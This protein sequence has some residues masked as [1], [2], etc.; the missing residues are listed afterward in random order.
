MDV[1]TLRSGERE[2]LLEL[3]DG[4]EIG[5]GWRGRDFFRR[6]LELDPTYA[7]ENVWVAV[8]DGRL[9]CCV[10]IFPRQLR[11]AGRPVPTGGIGS[12]FSRPERRGEGL[13]ARV[14]ARAEAA[15]AERGMELA[16]LF[17]GP[18]AWYEGLGWSAWPRRR[19]LLARTESAPAVARRGEPFDAARDL[20]AVRA[21]HE[22]CDAGREGCVIRDD[23]LWHASLRV[24]GNPR[25]DFLVAR[26]A[27]RLVAYARAIVLN[28]L[29]V[30]SEYAWQPGGADAL[31]GLVVE[32]MAARDPDPLARD[33]G[34]EGD[35]R[36]HAVAGA[37]GL[38]AELAEALARRGVG[39]QEVEDPTTVLRCLD[40][41]ALA[42]R[43]GTRL[44]PGESPE[45]LMARLAPPERFGFWIA[46]RF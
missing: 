37:A 11:I 8:E 39:T 19:L 13:G 46:D 35:L 33:A 1:R 28:G 24:A 14:L 25:E 15:M 9:E 29:F 6:Y 4:W 17:A 12:V 45:A 18:V 31:A 38:D 27:D 16:L 40:A 32:L 23:A 44:A 2:A 30:L 42:R 7:D 5:D 22:R 43:V 36:H 21:L 34:R 41:E 20:A 10:Q 26:A 3:L